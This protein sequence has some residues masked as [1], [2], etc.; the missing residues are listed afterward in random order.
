MA[1]KINKGIFITFE[2]PEGCG[3]STQSRRLADELAS[4]G[5]EVRYTRE[6]GDTVLGE[7]IRDII[8]GKDEEWLDE[9]AE[10]LLFEADRAQHVAEVIRPA[11]QKKQIVICDRYNTATFAYQGYGL[12]I[13][14]D[15]IKRIDE[16]A[17]GGLVPDLVILMDLDVKAGLERAGNRG[18]ADRMEKRD[19]E[20]H[21]KV[22]KGYLD[23]AEADS[24]RIKVIKVD[25]GIDETYT[26]VKDVVDV[27][28]RE[29]K[30][31]G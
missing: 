29:H 25:K 16:V 15:Q 30:G 7:S 13:D 18:L 5:Y 26:I 24:N 6:P 4:S 12:G 20:F 14:M 19:L 22:R 8:L 31:T 27:A 11:L 17:T 21:E 1:Q 28:I 9:K 2:G 3:K 10:L 23:M